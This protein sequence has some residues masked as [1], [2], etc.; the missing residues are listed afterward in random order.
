MN[1]EEAAELG[2]FIIK[3]IRRFNLCIGNNLDTNPPFDIPTIWYIPDDGPDA[4]L[5]DRKIL[6]RFELNSM[7][8]LNK[9]ETNIVESYNKT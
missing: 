4:L 7:K 1:M 5:T 3:Y 8:R 9:L 6:H 2:Y